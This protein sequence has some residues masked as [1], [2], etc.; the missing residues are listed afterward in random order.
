MPATLVANLD[1]NAL[2]ALDRMIEDMEL[3][4]P[5]ELRG[6]GGSPIERSARAV[7]RRTRPI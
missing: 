2:T 4:F 5:R 3:D 1:D 6:S 7:C